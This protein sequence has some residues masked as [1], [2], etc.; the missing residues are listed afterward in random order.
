MQEDITTLNPD[1][2]DAFDSDEKVAELLSC[3]RGH[4]WALVKRGVLPPPRKIGRMSRWKRSEWVAAIEAHLARDA[5]QGP[6]AA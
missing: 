5:D 4:V 6:S 1:G 3:S 2:A